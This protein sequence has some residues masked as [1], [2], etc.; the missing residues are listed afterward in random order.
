MARIPEE[1]IERIKR[2][3]SLERLVEASGVE[4]KKT[5]K[6]LFGRCPFHAPDDTPSLSVT[7]SKNLWN[8][9][10]ACKEGGDVF[11]WVMKRN[12][13]SFRHAYEL[14]REGLSSIAA[15]PVKKTTVR[16]L[17]MPVSLDADDQ[18]LRNQAA[19]SYYPREFKNSPEAMGYAKARGID[20]P[21][22]VEKFKLGYANRTLGLRLPNSQ[23]VTGSRVRER[24]QRIG[25]LRASGHEHFNGSLVIPIVDEAGNVVEMYGRKIIQHLRK[26]TAKHLY[27]PEECRGASRGVWNWEALVA[28]KE[29]ILCEAL[30]DA[31]TFWCAGYRNVTSAYGAGVFTDE[32]LAAMKRHGT[33][34]VLIAFDRDEPGEKGAASVAER[35][36]AAG[37]EAWR[38]EF[39]KGM[40]ANEYALKV[41]PA[42]KSLG[43]AIRKAQ[44]LGKGTAP[45]RS[46]A[47]PEVSVVA[48]SSS[49]EDVHARSRAQALSSL[50][51]E[52]AAKEKTQPENIP[53][54]CEASPATLPAA[55]PMPLAA[56]PVAP[57]PGAGEAEP[58]VRENEILFTFG[59]RK[60]RVRGLPKSAGLEMKVNVLARRRERFYVDTLNLASQRQVTGYAQEAARELEVKTEV[61]T[62]DLGS[63]FLKLELLQDENLKRALEPKEP[64][65]AAMG[66]PE[67]EAAA[68][69]LRSP[70]LIERIQQDLEACGLVG[71]RVNKLVGYLA[72]T[73]RK[74]DSPLAV[75]VQSS[76]AA[77][78]STLM[79]A[80]L[81]MMPEEE[82]VKYSAM[83]GQALFYLGERDLKHKILAIVE[84]EGAARAA[85]ALKLLQS[86]GELTIAS[87]GKDP[88]TGNLVTQPYRVEGPTMLFT[89]TTAAEIDPELQNR[90]LVLAVDES[91][92][93]TQAIHRLQRD[94]RTLEG[95]AKKAKR[96]ELQRLHQNAQR[97]LK[98]LEVL[99]PYSDRLTFP[100]Q[101]TRMRRDHEK[102]LTLID[103][104]ALLHQHQREVKATVREGQTIEYVEA[105]LADV[106]LANDLAHEVLGRSLDELPPQTRRV[107]VMI[108]SFVA[109]RAKEQAIERAQVRFSRR[110]LREASSV[111]DTQLRLHLDRL[112]ELEYVLARRD[113]AG[114][115]FVYEL[116]YD[117]SGRDGKPFVPCLIDVE[118]LAAV[119]K[120]TTTTAEVAGVKG[121]VA[122]RLRAD[123]GPVAG[124]SRGGEIAGDARGSSLSEEST[125]KSTKTHS[126]KGNGSE[127]SYAQKRVV[128]LAAASGDDDAA[129]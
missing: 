44:W 85:Y 110:E 30:I 1:E 49:L 61:V 29:I 73:S 118:R 2:E 72:A 120:T 48:S 112:I 103:I 105:T 127:P 104:I 101:A 91:R 109:A 13:V 71:E 16:A 6:D 107:L 21:E 68:A 93:Q 8:C 18:G 123:R 99:N 14:L 41:Q 96:K 79:D 83:T 63:V 119:V 125:L 92:E 84:E 43:I 108:D 128:P 115:R 60:Y 97:L 53:E 45:E 15:S 26:G 39:P 87:T 20:H 32:M 106:A 98:P 76:S 23:R 24:L 102:Y 19:L 40:D 34:R 121:E 81:A 117:G 113:G 77:G 52:L 17:P 95:L 11:A 69:L 3:V 36:I 122:G 116:V 94:K 82:R 126:K 66:E 51:A 67:R 88:V 47:V 57:A 4:L 7:P 25:I 78:K 86:E 37:I 31:L 59:D 35:L 46:E 80:V 75:L 42:G 56:S 64:A 89:T 62:A 114:G 70:Q 12:G 54:P 129:P 38:I 90:C 50:A 111:G 10:G 27:L 124:R 74:L 22:A 5:G 33:E 100:D 58:E 65:A 28:S 55:S 9:L